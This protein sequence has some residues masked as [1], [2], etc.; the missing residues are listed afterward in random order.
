MTGRKLVL[1]SGSLVLMLVVSV[2]L[3]NAQFVVFDTA[4]TLKDA[5][6]AGLKELLR[7]TLGDEADRLYKMAKRL[8][9]FADLGRFSISDDDTPKW[10]IHVFFGDEFL[11]A[12]PYNAALNYGDATGDAYERVARPRVSP[13]IELTALAETAP[14]AAAAL[15]AELATLD[16]ADSSIIASTNQTG[17]L[18][19]NGRRELAAIEA[20]QDDALDPSLDQ[21]ATAVLDKISG[22]GLIRAQQQQAR[23]QFLAGI[24]EQLLVDNKRDRDTE[25]ATMNMQL[26]RLRWGSAVNRSLIAG[27][28]DDL[29]A[30][31][32]P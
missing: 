21:S 4:L 2:G 31:R 11:F 15:I 3:A 5:A 23:M 7:D 19:Y 8:S 9:A 30:W 25:A 10:R 17:L 1:V 18:R 26:E 29:R 12:N 6:I 32:Q 13:G 27:A 14:A 24:V 16:A 20:L 28:G 22:A